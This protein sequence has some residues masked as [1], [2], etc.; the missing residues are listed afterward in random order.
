MQRW[1]IV[2]QLL[3]LLL[4]KQTLLVLLDLKLN[5][6]PRR[7]RGRGL[8]LWGQRWIWRR[9]SLDLIHLSRARLR[10]GFYVYFPRDQS[11]VSFK[12]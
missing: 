5:M 3:L 9:G 1:K 6:L 10:P 4:C 8:R 7:G 12:E 2:I 11:P